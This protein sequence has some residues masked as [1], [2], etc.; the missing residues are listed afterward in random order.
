[1]LE[2]AMKFRVAFDKMEAEDKSYNNYFSEIV[3]G[4]TLDHQQKKIEKLLID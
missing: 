3:D 1:M 2:Q 4:N